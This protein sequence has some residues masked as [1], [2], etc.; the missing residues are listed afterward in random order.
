MIR[1]IAKEYGINSNGR[2]A[3][4][5]DDLVYYLRSIERPI[6]ILDEAGDMN[7]ETFAGEDAIIQSG[8]FK[9]DSRATK[10][11]FESPLIPMNKTIYR[12]LHPEESIPFFKQ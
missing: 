11:W 1:F 8:R 7:Y 4:V 12:G 10:L 3:D 6:I 5:Y 9:G 2:Y